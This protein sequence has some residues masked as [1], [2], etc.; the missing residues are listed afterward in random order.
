MFYT[1]V[2]YYFTHFKIITMILISRR[3]QYAIIAEMSPY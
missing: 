1:D 3:D 2:I